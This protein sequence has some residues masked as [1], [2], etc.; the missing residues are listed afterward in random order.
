MS[1]E[2]EKI[3]HQHR[4]DEHL[5]LA[6]KQWQDF[7]AEWYSED[8]SVRLLPNALPEIALSEVDLSVDVLGGRFTVP[9][10][11]EAMTGGSEKGDVVNAQLATIARDCDLAM[12]VGSQSIALKYPELAAGFRKVREIHA[13]GFL[14]ANIGAG[15]D[16]EG[17]KRAVD[18]IE[19]NALEI[20]ING[21]QEL[22]M[23][24]GEGDRD[25]HWLDTIAQIADGVGV[26]VV[27]KEVGFG[28]SQKTFRELS[29]TGVA[30]I[31]VGGAGGTDFSEIERRRGGRLDMG[32]YG[33]TA[34]E[35]LLEAKLAHN[36]KPLIATGG[37]TSALEIARR[38]VL[39]ATLTSSAGFILSNLIGKGPD[40]TESL[41]M[42][43]RSD[44]QKIYAALGASN[45]T[46]LQETPYVLDEY[47]TNFV[48]QRDD[49]TN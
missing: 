22:T 9:F 15:H 6:F 17:A 48:R 5:S 21:V 46:A 42:E 37:L 13:Q 31:N 2:T 49:E 8:T 35:S 29:E 32:L 33:L 7:N 3:K 34:V 14:F 20:H 26:P 24:D 23:R 11:I 19:A 43:W 38:L 36:H 18:M 45:L 40:Q 25:F 28:M 16:L 30:A 4:K 44:L 39:G 12:A 27:V 10:Y 41:L 1:D 47:L